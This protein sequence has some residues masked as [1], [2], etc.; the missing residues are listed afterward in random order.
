MIPLDDIKSFS[1]DFLQALLERAGKHKDTLMDAVSTE[2]SKFLSKINIHEEVRK[3]LEGMT[4][5]LEATILYKDHQGKSIRK[6]TAKKSGGRKS[7]SVK[8]D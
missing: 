1:R 8:A 5:R 3:I 4:I 7:K 2:V 6:L